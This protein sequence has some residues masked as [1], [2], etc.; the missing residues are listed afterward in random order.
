[1]LNFCAKLNLDQ[2]HEGLVVDKLRFRC[3]ALPRFFNKAVEFEF[4]MGKRVR[5]RDVL[6]VLK[7]F[8]IFKPCAKNYTPL[9]I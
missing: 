1:M 4:G 2:A 5:V 8:K 6:F 7:I 3:A 9:Y